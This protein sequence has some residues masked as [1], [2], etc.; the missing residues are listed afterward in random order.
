MLTC[1]HLKRLFLESSHT[2]DHWIAYDQASLIPSTSPPLY[3]LTASLSYKKNL[4]T[5]FKEAQLVSGY[6]REGA[7]DVKQLDTLDV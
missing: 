1:P 3:G 7:G 2:C 4:S 6:L 5:D